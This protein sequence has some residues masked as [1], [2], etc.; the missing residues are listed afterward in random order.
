LKKIAS[1]EVANAVSAF[2]CRE[3]FIHRWLRR[4]TS[5]TLERFLPP[6]FLFFSMRV[7]RHD[8]RANVEIGMKNRTPI[9]CVVSQLNARALNRSAKVSLLRKVSIPETK[10]P[11]FYWKQKHRT[12][13]DIAKM[14]KR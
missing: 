5:I 11:N 2:F 7:H 6:G 4:Q 14:L 10:T 12:F 3:D 8:E 1:Q 9:A 13:T